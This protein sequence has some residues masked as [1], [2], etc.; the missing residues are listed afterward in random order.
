[1]LFIGY[2]KGEPNE[3]LMV[4]SGGKLSRQG[5]GLSFFYWTPRT[6]IVSI[7]TG[8][9]DVPFILNET[10]GNFQSVT[11]QGQLT[12]RIKDPSAMAAVLNFTIN[13]Y[14]RS[15][16]SNDP[17]KPAQRIVNEVQS[18]ARAELQNM[19]LEDALRQSVEIATRVLGK[20]VNSKQLSAIGVEVTA[21][22]IISSKPTP[23]MAKALEAEYRESLQTKADQA[24]YRRRNL[25]VEQERMI[26]E[27]ELHS[28]ITLEQKRRELVDLEG[29]NIRQQ[30]DYEA[31][32][33]A[34]R[35]APFKEIPT[36]TLLAL[37]IKE[38]AGNAGKIGN[39]NITP[40]ILA[41]LL[42]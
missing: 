2:F 21:L 35:L 18:H 38:L 27:N 28:A 31:Q 30:A 29:Q 26:K 20:L 12:Y 14:T 7:P 4:Y 10:T 39:L 25:A 5:A 24:I 42:K 40:D 33:T 41:S 34:I 1:M 23:E 17:E 16:L 19:P 13:P 37:S 15:F 8:T 6:S 11:L 3:Y 32:A 9:I 36:P 22:H